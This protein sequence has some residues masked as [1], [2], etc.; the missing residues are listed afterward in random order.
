MNFSKVI[1]LSVLLCSIVSSCAILQRA[2]PPGLERTPEYPASHLKSTPSNIVFSVDFSSVDKSADLLF[3]VPPRGDVSLEFLDYEFEP[4]Q[5]TIQTGNQTPID[6]HKLHTSL[7]KTYTIEDLGYMRFNRMVKVSIKKEFVVVPLRYRFKSLRASLIFPAY[8]SERNV[9]DSAFEDEG[10]GFGKLARLMILNYED[11]ADFAAES[12]P[13]D[14]KKADMAW[15]E[16]LFE[17]TVRPHIYWAKLSI[18]HPGFYQVDYDTLQTN[19]ID[20]DRIH[21]SNITIFNKGEEVPHLII[22]GFLPTFSPEDRVIFYAR[23]SD[24]RFSPENVYWVRFEIDQPPRQKIK[25][26]EKDDYEP[27]SGEQPRA[28]GFFIA[29]KRVEDD[30]ELKI[31]QG[32][33]LAIKGMRWVDDEIPLDE[34]IVKRFDLPVLAERTPGESRI[35]FSFYLEPPA[36]KTSHRFHLKFNDYTFPEFQISNMN[37]D[38]K[39]LG[40]PNHVFKAKDNEI[41]ISIMHE[42]EAEDNGSGVYLD[43]VEFTYPRRIEAQDG[44]LVIDFSNTRGAD[45]ATTEVIDVQIKGFNPLTPVAGFTVMNGGIV[46][47]LWLDSAKND[48]TISLHLPFRTDRTFHFYDIN[49]LP[50]IHDLKQHKFADLSTQPHGYEYIII[51]HENFLDEANRIVELKRRQGFSC[52]LVDVESIY[53]EF[54]FGV[55][56]P[57]P[58]KTFLYH[59]LTEWPPPQPEYVL[60]IGDSTSDYLR[61]ARNDVI[62][63]IPT[64]TIERKRQDEEWA[65]DHWFTALC[66]EDDF[67]DLIIGRLSVNNLKD[68]ETVIDK[69]ITY[70]TSEEPGLWHSM[71][72]YVADNG[73]FDIQCEEL[74]LED[75]PRHF[76]SKT[77]YLDK[78][79]WEDNFYLPEKF[80]EEEK[81]KVSTVATTAIKEAIDEGVVLLTFYGHGSPNIWTDE[82]IWFGG[83]SDNSDNLNLRNGNKL[84][85][86]INMACNSG[87]IDYPVPKWN[88]CISEDFM[89]VPNGG[90]IGL[91][92]PAGPGFTS[93]HKQLSKSLRNALFQQGFRRI[94]DVIV[95]SHYHYLLTDA[96][97]DMVKMY[98]LLGDPS[99]KLKIPDTLFDMS[100]TPQEQEKTSAMSFKAHATTP[101]I[102]K[103]SVIFWVTNP[104]NKVIIPPT[105]RGI[106]NSELSLDFILPNDSAR[107]EWTL[108]AYCFS[109]GDSPREA[110]GKATFWID[111]PYLDLID[112]VS[113]NNSSIQPGANTTTL[114][115]TIHNPGFL[116][117]K[118]TLELLKREDDTWRSI[119][120]VTKTF[121]PQSKEE[122]PFDVNP[123]EGLNLFKT[124]IKEYTT[125]PEPTIESMS[126]RVIAIPVSGTES[127]APDIVLLSD[128]MDL[129]LR[130]EKKSSIILYLKGE[131]YN[132]GD[133][134]FDKVI[135]TLHG[136]EGRLIAQGEYN[137]SLFRNG[138][139]AKATLR[140]TFDS[141]ESLEDLSLVAGVFPESI[142][143][144]NPDNNKIVFSD[145]HRS[146]AD[147]VISPDDI[148]FPDPRPTEGFTV[149][150]DVTVRNRGNAPARNLLVAAYNDDPQ[151]GGKILV[152]YVNDQAKEL[153]PFLAPD[154]KTTVRLRWDP[155]KNQGDNTIWVRLDDRDT[156]VESDE[157]NNSASK[158][159]YVKKKA[160]IRPGGIFLK[161]QTPEEKREG[162]LTLQAVVKN[163]GETDARGIFVEFFK[164]EQQI[165][166]ELIGKKYI[167]LIPAESKEVVEIEWQIKPEEVHRKVRPTYRIFLKGS[168]QR[169][170]SVLTPEEAEKIE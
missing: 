144:S 139:S 73:G 153:I 53:D 163:I 46:R 74:R 113:R 123:D 31:H 14:V 159:L 143:D 114:V 141:I 23:K 40:I 63:Y 49:A 3:F 28:P 20:P 158:V 10:R 42:E 71:L 164:G 41:S 133:D 166:E 59:A 39:E 9:R 13:V 169:I 43:Y 1:I 8:K 36:H 66:G 117:I 4:V 75:T 34:P 12:P 19:T 52:L 78:L 6:E 142:K 27:H 165:P 68:A 150:I 18:S 22:G 48:G 90:A 126:E 37:D 152:N 81:A 151:E 96:N 29:G 77:I 24:T 89:R 54:G 60:L 156:I 160:I 91:Y 86:I 136:K 128:T 88:I 7:H 55:E 107:G 130:R 110:L 98:I 44:S 51:S 116:T 87:A 92:V 112:L 93:H 30:Q 84:P 35:R 11:Y 108:H 58:I 99:M 121:A 161:P 140:A 83:D 62:N 45:T 111:E 72:G 56:S 33:F 104:H 15:H 106:T 102:D 82:R 64:Y 134:S 162:I 50:P 57:I 67:D 146:L 125:P 80:V 138:E 61:L 17:E 122:I 147:L 5:D 16:T 124:R 118:D 97:P 85:F 79:P 70:E 101:E 105:D 145:I 154:S 26:F 148:S 127:D 170:S 100:I 21:P 155:V 168:L 115:A 76:G 167:P 131:I 2:V 129:E 69:I 157:G 103:G 95:A 109:S 132:L 119:Y 65:S 149:F 94:G 25:A 47:L 135:L 120:E 32:N 137:E 38:V